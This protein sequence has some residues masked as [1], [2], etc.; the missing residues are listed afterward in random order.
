VSRP[1]STDSVRASVL[2]AVDEYNA[3]EGQSIRP[4]D[5]TVLL[6]DG[7]AV[8]SLGLVRL[9][10]TVERRVEDDFGVAVSLTDDKAMSQ[11]NSPFRTVGTLVG[12]IAAS[13]E[14]AR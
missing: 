6:G 2:G 7:G 14:P 5:D 13:L 11:R 3:S 9:I 8:D 4:A 12:Y 1:V 10:M